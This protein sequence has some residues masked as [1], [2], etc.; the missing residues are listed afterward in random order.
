MPV[1]RREFVLGM[2]AAGIAANL[3]AFAASASCPFRLSVINDEL[4]QDFDRAC[5]IAS[6]DFGLSWIELRGMWNKNITDLNAKEIADARQILKKYKLRVTDIA[7]PLFKVDWPGAP[8]SKH[9]PRRDQFHADFDFKQQDQLLDHCIELTKAFETD[10]IRCFDFWRLDNP[11]PYRAA[12]NE[13]LREAA[14]K[15]A[16]NNVI[17]LLE[18]EMACN[19]GTGEEAVEVLKAIPNKN[20]MLNWDPGNA[21]TFPGNVPYPDAYNKLPK[22]RIGHCHCKDVKRDANGKFEWEPVGGGI[23]D[24]VGQFKALKQDGY[25]YAVSLETH[26]RGAGTPEASTRVSM[27]GLKESLQKAGITC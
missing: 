2:A 9:S 5:Q 24:W 13:K 15:C 20:F 6:Q 8:L 7:S 27:K 22:E 16:K 21:G 17:L 25:H 4:T 23:I 11:A 10:R 3:P 14:E 12:M 26:W 1:S 19:T 18:N